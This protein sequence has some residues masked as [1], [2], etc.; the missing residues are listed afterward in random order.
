VF[1]DILFYLLLIVSYLWLRRLENIFLLVFLG[2]WLQLWDIVR[3]QILI[4]V[5]TLF[6]GVLLRLRCWFF[7]FQ[8][9]RSDRSKVLLID[10]LQQVK[11]LYFRLAIEVLPGFWK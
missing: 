7:L 3:G 6:V 1:L 9:T 10:L 4:K 11:N 8:I 2:S 5:V